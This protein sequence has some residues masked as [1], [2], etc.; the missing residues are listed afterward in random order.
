MARPIKD[1]LDY[2]P[3][4]CQ[5][6]DK[7]EFVQAKHGI[8]GYA[9][10]IKLLQ[11]IYFQGYHLEWNDKAAILFA[12]RNTLDIE[13][14]NNIISD[15]IEDKIFDKNIFEKYGALTSHGI[16]KRYIEATK[17]RKE[18][19]CIKEIAL[20]DFNVNNNSINVSINKQSKV[21]ESKEKKS[22]ATK[23]PENFSP[24]DKLITWSEQNWYWKQ[25]LNTL[26]ESCLDHFRSK[27]EKRV[28]WEA[29]IRNW[30][31]K[32]K[33]FHPEKYKQ[34]PELEMLN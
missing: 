18:I 33:E 5:M 29:T 23:P 11:K 30:C 20:I 19:K 12:S 10:L 15:S 9:V 32:D 21:K 14:L 8:V 4:D 16:Q 34:S 3:L 28:D 6:D 22:I 13:T 27:G 24:S 7:F 26:S 17:R 1:G 25:N 2:F 31:K